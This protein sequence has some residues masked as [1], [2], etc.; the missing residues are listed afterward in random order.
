MH[1]LLFSTDSNAGDDTRPKCKQC[2]RLGQKCRRGKGKL[3][4]R[5]GSSARYDATFAKDQTW[6]EQTKNGELV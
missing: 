4:F 6:L 3:K 2:E 5:H 1:I